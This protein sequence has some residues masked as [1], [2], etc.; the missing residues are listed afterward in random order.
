VSILVIAWHD[1]RRRLRERVALFWMFVAPVLFVGFFGVLFRPTSPR[2]TTL[3][4]VN[5]DADDYVARVLGTL[6]ERN[7]IAVARADRV[8]DEGFSL[9]IPPGSAAGLAANKPLKPVFHTGR[10]ESNAERNVSFAVIKALMTLYLQTNPDSTPR[11]IGKEDL[12]KRLAANEVIVVRPADLGVQNRPITAGFQRSVPA[13]LIMFVFMNLLISGAG[14]A[15]ERASGRLRRLFVMPVSKAEIVLGELLSRFGIG[16]LQIAWMLALGVYVFRIRWADHPVVLFGF[17]SLYALMSASLGL[18]LGT[19]FDDPDKCASAAI[20]TAILMAPLGG[21][22]WP[23][24]IVGPAMRR[25]AY[26]IPTGWA[27]EGVNSMLAFGA[28]AREVAPFALAFV[29][30]FVVSVAAAARRLRA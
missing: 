15:E 25:V 29:A 4:V 8:P 21:L 27:M 11:D 30:V 24:E 5:Q 3:T 12:E 20:W 9:V 14:L 16:V 28:G 18:F 10:E 7:R 17:L 22:W 19:L 2:P 13:Y 1:L 26:L 6:L 23:L